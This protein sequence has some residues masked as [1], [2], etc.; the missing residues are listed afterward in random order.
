MAEGFPEWS[1]YDCLAVV[2]ALC[3]HGRGED[4]RSA[5]VEEITEQLE[6]KD[7]EE[8]IRYV[9]T[10]LTL[11]PTRLTAEN[12]VRI[13]WLRWDRIEMKLKKEEGRRR[14]LQATMTEVG[15]RVKRAQDNMRGGGRVKEEAKAKEK[16]KDMNDN[17]DD[18]ELEEEE[19]DDDDDNDD[20]DGKEEED[21]DDD[22]EE[23]ND[24][25]TSPL[26]QGSVVDDETLVMKVP[27][28]VNK[29][30]SDECERFLFA[31]LHKHG[32]G[33]YVVFFF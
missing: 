1:R 27:G 9:K 15:R 8:V 14:E 18:D 12:H 31:M 32:Y 19:E 16:E 25:F 33:R 24:D 13:A 26:G 23:A 6:P 30:Y 3:R 5:V 29:M 4:S 17:D 11:G 21:D 28:R 2:K 22:E 10:F 20:D 7:E